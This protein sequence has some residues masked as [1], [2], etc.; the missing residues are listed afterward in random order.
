MAE[1]NFTEAELAILDTYID[2]T[3]ALPKAF[4]QDE[5]DERLKKL[6]KAMA[7]RGLDVVLLASPE[8]QC[9]LH[10]YQARW[11]RTGSTTEWPPL[12]FTAVTSGDLVL[13]DSEDHQ[14]LVHLTSVIKDDDFV[15]VKKFDLDGAHQQLIETMTKDR[16]HLKPGSKWGI[17]MWSPRQ[18]AATTDN[19]RGHLIT[20][21]QAKLEDV[22]I[23]MRNLQRIKTEK[24]IAVMKRAAVTLKD[25]YIH[26]TALLHRGMTEMQAWAEFE[27]AMAIRDGET[28]ALHNTFA[29]TRNYYHALSTTRKIGAGQFHAD[30]SAVLH[31]Y[32]VNAARQFFLTA[33]HLPAPTELM[34]ASDVAAGAVNVI[35][36][37]AQ[38]DM[39]FR[40]LASILKGYYQR[41]GLW[42]KRDW[43]GGYQMGIS[44]TPDWVGEFVWNVD[45]DNEPNNYFETQDRHD[46]TPKQKKQIK[47]GLV[48][49]FESYVGGAGL[50][51][52]IVFKEK[53]IDVLTQAIPGKLRVLEGR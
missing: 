14:K 9:W 35:H 42:D 33:P 41:N 12:N 5:Y 43:I 17:E 38:A 18:N 47:P 27:T 10:G 50:I 26:L 6:R 25:A 8:S 4:E 32:H 51:E 48:T 44:F 24:E 19:L 36:E 29:K 20:D 34:K 45:E 13:F 49:N 37:H 52:T 28:A 40:E 30:P 3:V 31:R 11:Y 46:P 1:Q 7:D 23:M 15:A 39:E 22:S 53:G 16:D 21:A 2:E